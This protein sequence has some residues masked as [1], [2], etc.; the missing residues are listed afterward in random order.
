MPYR[1]PL[2]IKSFYSNIK[3]NLDVAVTYQ[4][5]KEHIKNNVDPNDLVEYL[6]LTTEQLV[7]RF[8]ELI[9]DRSDYLIQSLELD[10]EE[11]PDGQPES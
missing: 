9:E 2:D 3:R 4:D 1:W 11:D 7:D 8:E 5:L 10:P 6:N